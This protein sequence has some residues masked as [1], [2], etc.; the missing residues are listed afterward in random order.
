MNIFWPAASRILRPSPKNFQRNYQ[1]GRCINNYGYSILGAP[2]RRKRTSLYSLF[3]PHSIH[4]QAE[5][6]TSVFYCT[7]RYTSTPSHRIINSYEGLP[8]DYEDGEGLSFRASS[9]SQGELAAIFGRNVDVASTNHMM[10]VLHGRRVA[11][12]LTD[13]SSIPEAR[14]FDKELEKIALEWLR[15]NVPL[16]EIDAELQ[17]AEQELLAAEGEIPA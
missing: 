10:R 17:R 16:D 6:L 3:S 11:G 13:L 12:T 9:L 8:S 14:I 5:E 15:K 7:R 1:V 4:S 2:F